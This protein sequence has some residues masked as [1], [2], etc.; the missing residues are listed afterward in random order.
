[1]GGAC[2]DP[3]T[4]FEYFNV[5]TSTKVVLL[6]LWGRNTFISNS[7][8]TNTSAKHNK[9]RIPGKMKLKK[10]KTYKKQGLILMR[11]NRQKLNH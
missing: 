10:T 2:W 8:W 11:F 4:K 1:M 9:K 7:L 5:E 3:T 6:Y